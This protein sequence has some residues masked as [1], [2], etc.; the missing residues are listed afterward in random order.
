MNALRVSTAL[1]VGATL[2]ASFASAQ[3]PAILL[4]E[5]EA[6]GPAGQLITGFGETQANNAGGFAVD[7]ST[8]DGT[9]TLEHFWG[10]PT[11]GGTGTILQTDQT[12]VGN[13]LITGFEGFFGYADNGTLAIGMT[14]TDTVSGTTGIDS[15]W[16]DLTEVLNEGDNPITEPLLVS[17]FNSRPGM[18]KSTGEPVWVGV[19]DDMGGTNAGERL[20]RGVGQTVVLSGGDPAPAPLV[21]N[22]SL[23]GLSFDFK[24]SA[25]GTHYITEIDTD[26]ATSGDGFMVIDGAI[27]T[28]CTG[29]LIGEGELIPMESGGLAGEAWDNF[30]KMGINEAGDFMFTGDTDGAT[31][32]DEIVVLNGTVVLREGD[33][34][35]DLSGG[36]HTLGGAVDYAVMN[37]QAD[38]LVAWNNDTG[39]E[40]LILNGV[41]ILAEGDEVDWDNDGALDAGFTLD[42][43]E[44]STSG[45]LSARSGGMV[46]VYGQIDVNDPVAMTLREGVLSMELVAPPALSGA[47]D[48]LFDEFCNGDGG[49][50]LG[51]TACPCGN[52]APMGT[53]GGCLNS[54]GTS[55]RL[56]AT[57]SASMM[58]DTLRFEVSSASASTFG[59][60]SSAMNQ[61]P[62]MGPCPP[63]SGILSP[64]LDGLRC[65]GG[66]LIRHGTRPSDVNGDI[67][68]TTNGWGP[69]NGPAGGLVA[70][71]GAAV[72]QTRN[73]Q[74]FYRED[75]LFTCQTG[76]NTTNAVSVVI[77]P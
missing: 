30:D 25:A 53:I 33:V 67:G 17:R 46:T 73:F 61:L 24:F 9:L 55:A 16:V 2:F 27:A 14:L 65:I 22:I 8:S 32:T 18:I 54:A 45:G 75:P 68:V 74:C 77:A 71:T 50:Q 38:I 41:V 3:N 70:Q 35:M 21:A 47:C 64:V 51:C 5:G 19:L 58:S 36:M 29:S 40:I 37:E 44:G 42:D 4:R 20:Y 26:L 1:F 63:G 60:L 48:G 69:P 59:I 7:V 57:G 11:T 13:F 31:A 39:D 12:T 52:N 23:G 62:N 15:V 56:L 6:F 28:T 34:L 72:G 10:F 49:D 66:G 43:L 76:Q